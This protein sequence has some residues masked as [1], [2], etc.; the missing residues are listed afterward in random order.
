MSLFAAVAYAVIVL[1]IAVV[2]LSAFAIAERYV[3]NRREARAEELRSEMLEALRRFLANHSSLE[4]AAKSLRRNRAIAVD[5]LV[6]LA[7]DQP[8]PQLHR[9]HGL[10]EHLRLH[11][12]MLAQLRHRDWT[13]RAHAATRLGML[14]YAKAV[15][16]LVVALDDA[17]LDVRLAAANALARLRAAETIERILES[18]ALPTRWPLQRCAEILHSMGPDAATPLT[19]LVGIGSLPDPET[20]AAI[21][22]LGMLRARAAVPVLV[23]RLDHSNEEIR[24]SSAKALGLIGSVEAASPL[25]T[26]LDD[27]AWPA[28][29]AAAQALGNLADRSVIPDLTEKL[30]DPAWWV[31]FNAAEALYRLGAAET[32]RAA[33]TRHDDRFARDISRQVLEE[34]NVVPAMGP[35]AP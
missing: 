4:E 15:P 23:T 6:T 30:A 1:M 3:M 16:A 20:A 33:M 13:R 28:R 25:R 12:R 5:A 27:P 18:L 19:M 29:S 7:D 9:L 24:I 35:A 22:A 32:L 31:R 17:L 11:Q 10:L 2:A 8:D 14:R 26:A 21:K 34:H